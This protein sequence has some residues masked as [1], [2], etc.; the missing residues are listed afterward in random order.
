MS[1]LYTCQSITKSYGTKTL[2]EDLSLTI[3]EGDRIGLIGL[4]GC[5]KSTFLKVLAGIESLEEGK[6]SPRRGL[7]VGYVAQT[8]DFKD[9]S[10]K[11]VLIKA[12][13]KD[14]PEYDRERLA[15]IQLEKIGFTGK[16]VSAKALSGGWKKRLALA[17]ELVNSPDL[18]LLDE[19]TNHLDLEGILWLEEF[20]KNETLTYLL[21]SHDRYFLQ[22]A[23]NRIIEIDKTYPGGYISMNGNYEDYLHHKEK[24][25]LGQIEQEKRIRSKVRREKEWLQAGVKARATKADARKTEAE[26]IFKEHADLKQRNKQVTT[27]INFEA[28][29]RETRKLL[30]ASNIAKGMGGRTLFKNLDFT[31]SP[32]T[33]I[34]LMGIN[35]CG[36]TTLLKLLADTLQPDL[37]TI[38]RADDLKLVYF[39]QHRKQ[40]SPDITLRDALSE[41]KEFVSFH[42][43]KI[44]INGW[45]KRFLFD[46]SILDMPVKTLSGG[47]RAR[48][49][50]AHLMLQPADVLLLDEPTN[51]LDI[52]TLETLEESLMEF[53]GAIVLIS[54]DR[55]LLDRI[56]NT[57]IGLGNPEKTEKYSGYAQWQ[58]AQNKVNPKKEAPKKEKPKSSISYTK[59]K[60]LDKIERKIAKLEKQVQDLNHKL[61]APEI[62][63]DPD[64]LADICSEVGVLETQIGQLYLQW[65]QMEMES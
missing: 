41:G 20:L 23:T 48:I 43:Q 64:M 35:G 60:D 16:E 5:G 8:C 12:M 62:A 29:D 65:E 11:D 21:V 1:V 13:R 51:D 58:Q 25:L 36:K 38:K 10:P 40:L 26:E 46:P 27:K 55:C 2:I 44:H 24:F 32:G 3:S 31:L 6:L 45:C 7:R 54:H 61:E 57:V 34:G 17:A 18:L 33:R 15:E 39:D 4:N 56:C 9:L 19:P 22:H 53:P 59:K 49:T 63:G 47:E 50:I 28:T 14:I 37:G 42:G 30:V 52:P